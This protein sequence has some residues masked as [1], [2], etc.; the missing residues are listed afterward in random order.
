MKNSLETRLGIFVVFVIIAAVVIVETLNGWQFFHQGVHISALFSTVQ[1]LKMGDQVKMAGVEIG[2]VDKI[3]IENSQVRVSMTI[4]GD[5]PVKTDS[6]ATIQFTGLMGQN[7]VSVGFGSTE[8]PRAVEGAVLTTQE[9]PDLN[10]VMAKL[11]KATSGIENL[12]KSFTPDTI[13]NL[14]GPL[15][16]LIKQNRGN[17]SATITNIE[18]ITGQ[19][20]SGQGTV[21]KLIYDQTLYNSAMDTVSNLQAAVTSAQLM[22]NNVTNGNGTIGKLITDDTLYNETTASMTNLHQILL[23]INNGNGT[24]GK[25][26]ND[27]DFYKNAQLSLQKLDKAADGLEDQGPLSVLGIVVSTLL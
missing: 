10:A 18:N 20:A 11:D 27:Q 25:L 14:L 21:G 22:I 7:F 12:T 1:D 4:N 2:K 15:T 9:Q 23:K 16:D 8:S 13:N 24:V 17:L 3:A 6:T 19:I 26:V 5:A